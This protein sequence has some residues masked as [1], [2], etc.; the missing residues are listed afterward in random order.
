MPTS[1]RGTSAPRRRSVSSANRRGGSAPGRG[2]GPEA[3]ASEPL[4]WVL[5]PAGEGSVIASL[6]GR[7]LR[8]WVVDGRGSRDFPEEEVEIA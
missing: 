8:V 6:P 5:T 1:A 2:R 7:K 4:D 3:R